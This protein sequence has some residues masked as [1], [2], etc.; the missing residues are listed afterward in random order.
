MCT[1]ITFCA[2]RLT[3]QAISAVEGDGT[4][5]VCL[6]LLAAQLSVD[7]SVQLETV[8]GVGTA[9]GIET[10]YFNELC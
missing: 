10:V 8:A 4:A 3:S 9:T 1:D 7:V 5:T 2:I 6:E